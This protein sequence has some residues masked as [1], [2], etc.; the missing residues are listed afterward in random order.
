MRRSKKRGGMRKLQK[1]QKAL[2]LQEQ[3]T[4][5]EQREL[6]RGQ[7]ELRKEQQELRRA[8]IS[9]SSRQRTSDARAMRRQMWS[10]RALQREHDVALHDRKHERAHI[11]AIER[12]ISTDAAK[13]TNPR[14]RMAAIRRNLRDPPTPSKSTL[15]QLA[16]IAN[17]SNLSDGPH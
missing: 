3:Q 5:K 9:M 11:A 2:H 12:R 14:A 6:H 15:E 1:R 13:S 4:L 16:Q 17:S 8:E 10:E 7:Q